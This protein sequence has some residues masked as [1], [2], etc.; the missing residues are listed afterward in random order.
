[1]KW[2]R[3]PTFA[4]DVARLVVDVQARERRRRDDAILD[5]TIEIEERSELPCLDCE[6]G[7]PHA[8]EREWWRQRLAHIRGRVCSDPE[9]GCHDAARLRVEADAITDCLPGYLTRRPRRAATNLGSTP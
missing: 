6:I 2:R 4:D 5:Q 9:C 1:M 8:C 7:E 3:K